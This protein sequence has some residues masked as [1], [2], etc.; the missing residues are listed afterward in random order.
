MKSVWPKTTQSDNCQ[1]GLGLDP[2][3]WMALRRR[4]RHGV[5]K[6]LG[7]SAGRVI[8]ETGLSEPGDWLTASVE[9]PA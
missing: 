9:Q 8:V 1:V 3:G 7:A 5:G 2:S 4:H 6:P